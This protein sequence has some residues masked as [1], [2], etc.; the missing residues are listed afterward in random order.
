MTDDEF[1]TVMALLDD[2]CAVSVLEATRQEALSPAELEARCDASL[3]TICRR[4][5]RLEAMDLLDGQTRL[6]DDGNH[7]TVYRATL[8]SISITLA[9]DGFSIAI[10]RREEDA[11][12]RL[13]QLWGDL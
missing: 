8:D 7:D 3:S 6:R 4:I 5:D 9:E 13:H 2:T 10:D 11:A 1:E 12:D